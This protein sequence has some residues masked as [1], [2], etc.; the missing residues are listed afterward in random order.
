[1]I[2]TGSIAATLVLGALFLAPR[3]APAQ[4]PVTPVSSGYDLDRDIAEYEDTLKKIRDEGWIYLPVPDT[5][6]LVSREQE[7]GL[8]SHMILMGMMSPDAVAAEHRKYRELT[9]YLQTTIEEILQDLHRQR[10]ERAA[11]PAPPPP[12]ALPT[13]PDRARGIVSGNWMV[14]CVV[15]GEAWDDAGT[16]TLTFTGDGNV[17]GNYTS[18]SGGFGVGGF[19]DPAGNAEGTGS[20]P[21]GGFTWRAKMTVAEGRPVMQ[22]GSVH[23]SPDS[24]SVSCGSGLLTPTGSAVLS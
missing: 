9:R 14:P 15:N 21:D 11:G 17:S 22:H 13:V 23:F 5:G 18:G 8:F 6:V 19:V 2:S 10:R 24:R 3:P 4:A 20:H 1:L 12:P 16:F 7:A